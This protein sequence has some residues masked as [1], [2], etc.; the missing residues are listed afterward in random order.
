MTGL[1]SCLSGSF[2][3]QGSWPA[4]LGLLSNNLPSSHVAILRQRANGSDM[5]SEQAPYADIQAFTAVRRECRATVIFWAEKYA[6]LPAGFR[7][8]VITRVWREV[9][10]SI[11]DI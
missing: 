11:R 9:R 6:S 7:A 8:V 4:G 2:R 3:T 1:R 5:S 10:K